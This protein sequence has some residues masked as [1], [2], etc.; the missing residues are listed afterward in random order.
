MKS[1]TEEKQ[2]KSTELFVNFPNC[3]PDRKAVLKQLPKPELKAKLP[4]S[5]PPHRHKS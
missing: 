5:S 3:P 1:L 4:R 2:S